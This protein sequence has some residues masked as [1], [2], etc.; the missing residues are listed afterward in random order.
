[1]NHIFFFHSSVE[2]YL[3]CFQFLAITNKA[4]MNI[5][6]YVGLARLPCLASVGEEAS[7]LSET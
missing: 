3:G 2:E 6:V 1:M 7:S 4:T 5:T